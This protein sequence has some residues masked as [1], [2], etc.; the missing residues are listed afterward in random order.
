M[1][2]CLRRYRGCFKHEARESTSLVMPGERQDK[3]WISRFR[4][5]YNRSRAVLLMVE[6][7][8]QYRVNLLLYPMIP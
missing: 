2:Q 6:Y 3:M 8:W 7:A 1:S 5:T 4:E